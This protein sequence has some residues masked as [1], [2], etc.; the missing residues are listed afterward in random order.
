MPFTWAAAT[1]DLSAPKT[2]PALS[3]W[4]LRVPKAQTSAGSCLHRQEAFLILRVAAQ[5]SV[6]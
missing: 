2:P 4:D 6:R 1:C 3:R 5:L